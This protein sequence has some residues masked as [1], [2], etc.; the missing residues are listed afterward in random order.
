MVPG[1]AE[2]RREGGDLALW[3]FGRD[4]YV[5]LATAERLQC[6]YHL[7]CTVVNAR[8]LK[9]FDAALARRQAAMMPVFS[10][11]DHVLT[12]GLASA[13]DEALGG[14][15]RLAGRFG[16]PDAVL[17]HGDV[18]ELRR[19]HGLLPEALA[20]AIARRLGQ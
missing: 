3:T 6:D 15:A 17:P 13:L 4:L 11:E 5:A 20:G 2:I 10:L 7:A 16:W 9:P 18:T 19:Q 14:D 1:Q 8:S 12:G